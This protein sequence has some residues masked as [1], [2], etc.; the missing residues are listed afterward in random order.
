MIRKIQKLMNKIFKTSKYHQKIKSK[1]TKLFLKLT[2]NIKDQNNI[3]NFIIIIIIKISI[4][5][6]D[7]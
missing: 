3:L 2:I 1:H 5:K 7:Y 6:R 4:K